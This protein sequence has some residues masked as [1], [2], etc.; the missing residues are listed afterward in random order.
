MTQLDINAGMKKK[1]WIILIIV[2]FLVDTTLCMVAIFVGGNTLLNE[3]TLIGKPAEA[4]AKI[5][6]LNIG[7][8]PDGFIYTGRE[9]SVYVESE[10]GKIFAC[11][12]NSSTGGWEQVSQ[13][14]SNE[15]LFLDRCGKP[16]NSE[17]F[18]LPNE[19]D[20]F[21]VQWCGEFENGR[22][23]YTLRADG[24]IW[25][26]KIYESPMRIT[27]LQIALLQSPSYF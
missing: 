19:K 2:L 12:G 14:D 8:A 10:T 13:K 26:R 20:R 21:E 25:F 6:G 5:V 1:H 9:T 15:T 23:A 22:V 16:E 3:W 4:A 18:H 17:I 27:W 24:T 7:K 11:C